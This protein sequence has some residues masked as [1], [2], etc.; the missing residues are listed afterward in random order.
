MCQ[1]K[2]TDG[3]LG[4][5]H[6][7]HYSSFALSGLGG[8]FIEA[9][10]VSPEGRITHGCSGLWSDAQ[11]DSLK[12][13]T[14]PFKEHGCL[15]GIQLSHAGRKASCFRPWD[16]AHSLIENSGFESRWATFSAS[17][18]PMTDSSQVPSELD[19]PGIKK[20]LKDFSNATR[21]A[22]KADFDMLEIHGAHGYLL[23]S[24]LSP[25]SNQRTDMYGGS[26]ENRIRFPLEVVKI[27]RSNWPKDK[28]LFYR[29]SSTDGLTGGITVEE[30]IILSNELKKLGVDVIDCSSGGIKGSPVLATKKVIPGYQ[31]PYSERIKSNASILT[32]AVGAIIHANQAEDIIRKN[33][34]DLVAIGRELL[35]D[36]QWVYRSCL[37]L[38]PADALKLLP[39]S[40]SFYLSRREKHL[41]RQ[42]TPL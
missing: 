36:T 10:A 16:G 39:E 2:A 18:I 42:A 3:I 12:K 19:L 31:V 38:A 29:V 27:V 20:V 6:Y 35:A 41:D 33:R 7:Q 26:F 37:E 9:T 13:I 40:Y 1:Y 8:A 22:Q 14:L 5:W 24:F 21:L 32:M 17:E 4:D 25:L 23:H 15:I 28:P 30:T 11:A 34:A